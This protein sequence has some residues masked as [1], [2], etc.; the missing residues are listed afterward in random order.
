[1]KLKAS[2]LDEILSKY[3]II[4]RF[5]VVE[6]YTDCCLLKSAILPHKHLVTLPKS[7]DK[8]IGLARVVI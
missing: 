1:M 2:K 8:K 5:V 6:Q 7:V 3:I 4:K